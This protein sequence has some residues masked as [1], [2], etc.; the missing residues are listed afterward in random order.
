MRIL[1]G[2]RSHA[3]CT[4]QGETVVEPTGPGPLRGVFGAHIRG[5]TDSCPNYRAWLNVLHEWVRA[6][7]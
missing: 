2:M 6:L 7:R 3:S 4:F 5:P 1:N